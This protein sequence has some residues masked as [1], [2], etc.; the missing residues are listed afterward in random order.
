M[1]KKIIGLIVCTL[2]ITTAALPVF[3]S[4]ASNKT[5]GEENQ[6]IINASTINPIPVLK[7][8]WGL[9][10]SKA[11]GGNGH[12][13]MAQPCGDIDQDGVNEVIIGG[14]ENSGICRILSYDT[15]K[16]TYIEEYSWYV[17][18]GSYHSPSGACIADLDGNGDL[19]L[20]VSWGY[21]GADGVYAYEWDGTTLTT[22]DWYHGVGVDFVFDIYACDYDDDGNIEVLIAN[23]PNMG[24]GDKH[25]SALGWD[26]INNIFT[27]ETSWSCPGG[28]NM[29][30]PMVW[31]GDIDNDGKTEVVADVSSGTSSTAGT[32]ALNW[33]ETTEEWIGEPIWTNYQGST[34]YGESVGDV[35]GNGIPEIGVGSYGGTPSGW[36][37]EWNGE[38]YENVWHGTY[39]GGQPVIE[40]VEINDADNDGFNE[41]CFGTRDIHIIAWDGDKYYEENTL[42]D[43][44]GM[45]AGLTIGDYDTDG[46]NEMK[47]CEILSGTGSE[48]IYKYYDETPPVTICELDGEMKDDI[49]ISDVMVYLNATDDHS[50]IKNIMFK[51]D[52]GEWQIYENQFIVTE[53][54]IHTLKFYSIDIYGNEEGQKSITFTIKQQSCLSVEIPKGF[55][56]GLK[57]KVIEMCNED[58]TDI[59]WKFEISEGKVIPI[60]PLSGTFDISS[61]ETK[62]I[63]SP[64]VFGLGHIQMIVTID[65]CE[66]VIVNGIIIG[67]VVYIL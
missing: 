36:L 50:I 21:S 34:V 17:P 20:C 6:G 14:Y 46:V 4:I 38:E 10:W 9:Q 49:F 53:D 8:G 7:E 11:Y 60:T 64:L 32:W 16:M 58:H 59:S 61:G 39:P 19:D 15:N 18:G 52:E 24:T 27:L 42:T 3:G 25:V 43:P 2:F 48:F 41:F 22:L 1:N 63:K 62:T 55:G 13:Q 28:S 30:C 35:N 40:S 45:L 23:A 12:A 47:A 65:D 51:L 44:T 67:A 66:P 29:E 31:S 57:A 5:I 26:S 37:F 33:D 54:G 56:F